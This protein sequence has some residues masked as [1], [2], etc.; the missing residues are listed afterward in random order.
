MSTPDC[1]NHDIIVA[2][3]PPTYSAFSSVVL[4]HGLNG[5]PEATWTTSDAPHV[6]WPSQLLPESLDQLPVRVFVY[7]YNAQVYSFAGS[8]PTSDDILH[9]AQTLITTVVSERGPAAEQRPII[10]ICHSLGGILVK[11]MLELSRSITSTDIYDQ[12]SLYVSTYAIIFLGTPH[13]GSD[14]A[15]WGTMAEAMCRTMLPK[16]LLDTEPG[17]INTLRTQSETLQNI[18]ASFANIQ[19]RFQLAFFHE[20]VKTDFGG[21]RAFVVERHSAAPPGIAVFA[22]IEDTHSGMCKFGSN[23]SPGYRLVVSNLCKYAAAAPKKIEARWS[24]E[25]EWREVERRARRKEL[26][27]A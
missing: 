14:L 11:K 3:I 22:G 18:N 8:H 27:G 24:E 23:R 13:F 16:K 25:H 1:A 5:H 20:A 9:H 15:K 26:D 2:C 21:T 17:L 19:A 4:V 12:R 7:G 10:W 6:F